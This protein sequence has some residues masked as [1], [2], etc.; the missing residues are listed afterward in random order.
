MAL[1]RE[2]FRNFTPAQPIAPA[3]IQA[4]QTDPLTEAVISTG[5]G[6]AEDFVMDNAIP[7]LT[8]SIAAGATNTGTML[9][10]AEAL[11]PLAAGASEAALLAEAASVAAGAATA[12]SGT[13]LAGLAAGAGTA[14]GGM[15]GA[16]AAAGPLM[17]AAA[18]IA[19]P[20]LIA[21]KMF[22]IF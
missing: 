10:A 11:G 19:I 8:N 18:P 12:A 15:T 17:A 22:K 1:N 21:A 9:T 13:G 6:I 7:A 5:T 2:M 14:A 4:K 20:L 16:L 3:Q